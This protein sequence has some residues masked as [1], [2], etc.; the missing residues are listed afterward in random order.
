[1]WAI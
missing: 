1:M